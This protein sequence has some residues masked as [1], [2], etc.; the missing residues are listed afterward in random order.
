MIRI[1]ELQARTLADDQ[2][3]LKET[4]RKRGTSRR[5]KRNKEMIKKAKYTA[6]ETK[7]QRNKKNSNNKKERP[8]KRKQ[9]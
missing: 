5:E 8:T 3:V 7:Q 6:T 1:S 4:P 2:V 9:Q